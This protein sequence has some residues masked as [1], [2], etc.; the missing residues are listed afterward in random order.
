MGGASLKI[1]ALELRS[2]LALIQGRLEHPRQ[3]LRECGLLLLRSVAKNFNQGGRPVRWHPSARALREGGQTLVDT[4]RLKNSIT[5]S[6]TDDTLRVGTNVAYAAIHQLGGKLNENVTV[7]QHYR[8]IT[9]AFGKTIP[10]RKVLVR[11]HQR[12]MDTYIPARPWLM[13]QDEDWRRMREIIADYITE[14]Q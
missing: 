4:A 1:N 6:V 9:Q 7:R 5:M 14:G 2:D 8:Q 12:Q 10:G 13:I 3:A 11:Q